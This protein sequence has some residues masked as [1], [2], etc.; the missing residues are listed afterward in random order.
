MIRSMVFVIAI[1][2]S[3]SGCSTLP[4][5]ERVKAFGDAA[6]T[7]SS[8]M[9][10]ALK[11][12]RMIAVRTSQERD[13]EAFIRGRRFQL[14]TND[15]DAGAIIRAPEQIAA[16]DALE[17][18]SRALSLAADQGVI[19]QLE[20]A[21]V[22]LG[23]AAGSVVAAASPL[24]AP[25]VGPALK[26]PARLF[27]FALGNQYAA[28]IQAVIASRD[29]DVQALTSRLIQQMEGV[30]ILISVQVLNY[31]IKRQ[32]ALKAVRVDKRVTR[33]EL[34]K[35]YMAARSDLDTIKAEQAVISN[36]KG[37][38]EGL[39]EAHHALATGRTDTAQVLA[40]FV[41]LANDIT[42]VLKAV[43]TARGG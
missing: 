14:E 30:R 23:E 36:Y 41:A 43:K 8:V 6:T 38:L 33:L 25:V 5:A 28:E 16:L 34:Y 17:E 32:E 21:S 31:E 15:I 20:E 11:A 26:V 12:N 24:A 10:N 7:S 22:N 3:T 9:K 19:D 35:E 40:K 27:G 37:I 2:A 29:P 18:Y 4:K 1:A 13:A 39:A 42:D